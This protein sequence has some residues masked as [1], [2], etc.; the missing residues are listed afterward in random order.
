MAL[1][2]SLAFALSTMPGN[3]RRSSTAADSW[4]AGLDASLIAAA[5]A[6][7]R[8]RASGEAQPSLREDGWPLNRGVDFSLTGAVLVRGCVSQARVPSVTTD[9]SDVDLDVAASG[10]EKYHETGDGKTRE[11]VV[12]KRRRIGLAATK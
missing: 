5:S 2:C 12:G 4:P 11:L 1:A 10:V 9:R 6:S 3:R 7:V 8:R